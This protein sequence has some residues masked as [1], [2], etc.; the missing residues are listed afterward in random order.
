MGGNN[1]CDPSHVIRSIPKRRFIKIR[2]ICSE[3]K[4]YVY[5][6]NVIV[7]H[8]VVRGYDE[9]RLCNSMKDIKYRI[10]N[11]L[12]KNLKHPKNQTRYLFALGSPL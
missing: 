6:S 11:T 9:K 10:K 5:H 3:Q 2:Q 8:F 4:D 7:E 12:N 1:S